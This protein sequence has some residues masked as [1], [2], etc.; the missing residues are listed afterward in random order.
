MSERKQASNRRNAATST[1]PKPVEGKSSSSR[2]AL[3]HGIF[4]S[5]SLLGNEDP[6]ESDAFFR[7]LVQDLRSQEALK[8]IHAERIAS[9]IW[10]QRRLVCTETAAVAFR[11]A[12]YDTLKMLIGVPDLARLND[13]SSQPLGDAELQQLVSCKKNSRVAR[14]TAGAYVCPEVGAEPKSQEC[15][16]SKRSQINAFEAVIA[17]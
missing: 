11:Q 17:R 15:D 13:L 4:G 8:L 1:G 3:R 6:A 16:F 10:R 5:G 9:T 2:N 7:S 14:G 12:T